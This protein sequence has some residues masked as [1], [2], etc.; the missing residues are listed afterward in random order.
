MDLHNYK[1]QMERQLELI[2]ESQDICE[3][4][5]KIMFGFKDYL[6][7]E[8]IGVAKIGRYLLDMRK[9]SNM[10]KKPF[11]EAN[12]EDIRRVVGEIEQSALAPES[13]KC[14]KI[15]LRKVYRYVRE[16]DEKGVYPPEVKWISIAI[17]K[18]HKKLPEELLAEDEIKEIIRSCK[19]VRDKALISSLAESG[20]RVSEIGLMKIKNVSFEGHGAKLTVNG[21][22][23]MR[24]ILV[25]HSTAYLQEWINQHPHNDNPDSYLWYNPQGELLTYSRITAILKDAAK[26]A[27]IKKRVYPHLLRHTRATR[28][29]SIMSEA[30]MKQYFGWAQSS[31]MCGIYIHMSGEVTDN[32]ILKANGIEVKKEVV[33]SKLK[34]EICLRC[35]TKNGATNRCCQHCGLILDEEYAQETIKK[36]ADRMQADEI[37]N[38]LMQDAEILEL[39]KK[40]LDK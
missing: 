12:K 22:T 24:K 7:S 5:K 32:A 14:F 27:G 28:L 29:A 35:K 10:L 40:K 34:Q 17:Q 18:N 37:M 13:K 1:R 11:P 4:N 6:L 25:I 15:M 31:K 23:G 2:D 19:N 30:A 26:I 21:K 38:K 36:D 3:E 8:A 33:E 9:L 39:I 16:V 20:C